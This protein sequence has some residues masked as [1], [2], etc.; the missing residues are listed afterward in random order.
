MYALSRPAAPTMRAAWAVR[1]P[2]ATFVVFAYAI[3]W[4]IA[5]PLLASARGLIAIPV[6]FALHYLTAYG[7]LLAAVIVTGLIGGRDGLRDLLRR[8]LKWRV[9]MRWLLVGAFSLIGLFALAALIAAALGRPLPNL[10]TLGAIN[11]LPNLGLLAWVMW[12]GTSGLGEEMGWRGFALPRLQRNHSALAATLILS[13]IWIG[14]HAPFFFYLTTYVQLGLGFVPFFALGILAGA[15]VLTWLYNST[16][17]S[18]LVVALWHGALN[19]VTA[20]AGIDGTIQ[21]LISAAI[22]VWAVVL[23]VV[24]KPAN[25][26]YAEKQVG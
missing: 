15:I 22:M 19:F 7:P 13:L 6:P 11:Y 21:A 14:W 3:T 5:L 18:V 25:L 10:R 24:C 9:G 20:P 8:A 16:H 26:S 23:V 12:I 4:I 2:I 1:H 17:G